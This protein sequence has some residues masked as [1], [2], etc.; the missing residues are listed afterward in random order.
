MDRPTPNPDASR[1][2]SAWRAAWLLMAGLLVAAGCPGSASKV[3]TPGAPTP[4]ATAAGKAA[5]AAA[6]GRLRRLQIFYGW[7]S[8]FDGATS[9]RQAAEK[10][11]CYDAVVLGAGLE[12]PKHG[13]HAGAR[14]VIGRIGKRALVF[15][16][17]PLGHQTGLKQAQIAA[18]L[19]AWKA[20]GVRGIF[21]DE[22]GYDYGNTRERQNA[23]IAAA[24][25]RGL[26]VFANAYDPADLFAAKKHETFNPTGA[27]IQLRAGD[28]YLYESFGLRLGRFEDGDERERKLG[29]LAA[30]RKLGV[31]IW[32]VTTVRVD[33]PVDRKTWQAVI[34]L[35]R[36]AKLY[37]L[38]YGAYEYGATLKRIPQP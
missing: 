21:F 30:A 24:H 23:A 9:P 33:G 28:H 10:L 13:D 37:G 1:R 18:R 8:G 4:G 17:I 25:A 29:Q 27:A 12:R 6:T 35:A 31:H 7:P 36:E 38:G 11:A 2:A 3:K 32:G 16:Y 14:Q 15:G 5:A 19:D 20:M 22:A 34:E 26:V